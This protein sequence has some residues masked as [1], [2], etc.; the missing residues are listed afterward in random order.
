MIG[1]AQCRVP[2]TSEV[3]KSGGSEKPTDV[4]SSRHWHCKTPKLHQANVRL[5]VQSFC[6]SL[7][8]AQMYHG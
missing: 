2:Q 8:D 5:Q 3:F 7:R 6:V 1:T 4:L